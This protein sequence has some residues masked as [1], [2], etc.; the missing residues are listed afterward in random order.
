MD[1]VKIGKFISELRKEKG[2]TQEQLGERVGVTNKTVSRWETGT[3]LPPADVLMIMSELFS[4]S[5]NELL[6]GRRLTAEEYKEAAEENLKQTIRTSSFTLRDRIDFYKKKWLKVSCSILLSVC[7]IA[8]LALQY[9]PYISKANNTVAAQLEAAGYTRVTPEDLGIQYRKYENATGAAV[10]TYS[11][12]QTTSFDMTYLDVNIAFSSQYSSDNSIRYA[13][14]GG[15]GISISGCLSSSYPGNT[16][17]YVKDASDNS[18]AASHLTPDTGITNLEQSFNLKFAVKY[19]TASGGETPI[20]YNMWINDVQVATDKVVNVKSVES[21]MSIIVAP[22]A[23]IEI[24][25]PD[26]APAGT[27]AEDV[28]AQ[29]QEAGYTRVTPETFGLQYKKYENT[30]GAAVGYYA[31]ELTTSLDMTYLDVDVAFSSQYSSNNSIRYAGFGGPGISISGCLSQSY[32]GNTNIYVKDASDNS[33]A[34]SHLTADTGIT[35]LEQSFNLKFAVKYGTANG[36]ETPIT[37]NMWINNVQVATNKVVNV[38][39]VASA[40]SIIVAPNAWIEIKAPDYEEEEISAEDVDAIMAE[41]GYTKVTPSTFALDG[42]YTSSIKGMPLS[43]SLDMHYLDMDVSF[44]KV[45]NGNTCIRFGGDG[46][47]G[48]AII[49]YTNSGKLSFRDPSDNSD[50]SD[51]LVSQIKGIESLADTFNLKMAIKYGTISGTQTI[52]TYSVWIN[53][54]PLLKDRTIDV[55]RIGKNMGISIG[56]PGDSITVSSP[57]GAEAEEP[58]EQHTPEELGFEEITIKDFNLS[59]GQYKPTDAPQHTV[60]TYKGDTLDGKY[61]NA[62]IAF[63]MTEESSNNNMISYGSTGGWTGLRI[64]ARQTGL[65]IENAS[66]SVGMDYTFKR[67][68]IENLSDMFNLK[69][70]VNFGDGYTPGTS[71]TCDVTYSLWINDVLIAQ[72][73]FL[74]GVAGTGSQMALYRPDTTI[75]ITRPKASGDKIE[76]LPDYRMLT[77]S[78]FG[79]SD[80]ELKYVDKAVTKADVSL[81]PLDGTIFSANLYFSKKR[82]GDFRL[83]GTDMYSGLWIYTDGDGNMNLYGVSQKGFETEQYTFTPFTAGTELVETWLNLKV[84]TKIVDS[85]GDGV[86]DDVEVGMWFNDVLYDNEY[87]YLVDYAQ[88]LG[89]RLNVFS[90]EAGSFIRAKNDTKVDT[91]VDFALFGFTENWEKE[92][93]LK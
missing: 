5:V 57:G 37:Y 12:K 93:G 43:K 6:S 13:G 31:E 87:I 71:A 33:D 8:G 89:I 63:D 70:G 14:F 60:K 56:T 29:L 84:S 20:T 69:L 50:Q 11:A 65:R 64:S 45:T 15:P 40:M 62:N 27:P 61:F 86:K 85:D 90:Q 44:D 75:T 73:M 16:N 66:N 22:G 55:A 48:I 74:P 26:S 28:N 72:D 42:T 46:D 18:D 52:V 47:T 53:N 51:I 54:V 91:S 38:K 34:A 2:L 23:W 67:L 83:G 35:N 17:I 39:S 82:G 88:Y 92:Y 10:G 78:H 9:I 36:G 1:L 59:A 76:K 79:L 80:M 81:F 49:G 19:G 7:L 30:T 25:D 4:V 24:K 77:L 68:G 3:Y 58:L 21:A 32:P 41:A